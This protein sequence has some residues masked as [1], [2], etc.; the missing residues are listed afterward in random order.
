MPRG[1]LNGGNIS[2]TGLD[3]L[4]TLDRE[5]VTLDDGFGT[6]ALPW[7]IEPSR[8][9]AGPVAKLQNPL[10]RYLALFRAQ[11]QTDLR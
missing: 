3:P 9:L 10:M 7:D 11:Q 4:R 6:A 8:Q 1:G 5:P 2:R